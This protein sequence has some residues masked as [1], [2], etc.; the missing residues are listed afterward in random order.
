MEDLEP[1]LPSTPEAEQLVNRLNQECEDARI[2]DML[3]ELPFAAAAPPT[4]PSSPAP[5]LSPFEE[6]LIEDA[7]VGLPDIPPTPVEAV[8]TVTGPPEALPPVP[9]AEAEEA[10]SD[11]ETVI[12]QRVAP[13]VCLPTAAVKAPKPQFNVLRE[14]LKKKSKLPALHEIKRLQTTVS[15]LIPLNSITRLIR[16][17]L[18]G[19]GEFHVTRL[20]LEALQIAGEAHL[21]KLMEE[22]NMCTRHG[23]RVTLQP[24]DIRLVRELNG[25][26]VSLGSTPES[27][28]AHSIE[29]REDQSKRLCIQEALQL[30]NQRSQRARQLARTRMGTNGTSELFSELN[31]FYSITLNVIPAF[32]GAVELW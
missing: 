18:Q 5:P 23:G 29:L 14:A 1:S 3:S 24:K 8:V 11:A 19:Y 30:E 25:D 31:C 13:R 27:D 6:G 10:D 22:A 28:E 9:A 4:P 16:E 12:I 32:A 21:V 2:T 15:P 7:P 26:R 17:I 20:C